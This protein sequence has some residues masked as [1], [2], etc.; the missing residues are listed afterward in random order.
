MSNAFS[1]KKIDKPHAK[2]TYSKA[3]FMQVEICVCKAALWSYFLWKELCILSILVKS[4]FLFIQRVNKVF[5]LKS[6][7][8]CKSRNLIYVVL[9]SRLQRKIYWRGLL[10]GRGENKYLSIA[11]TLNNSLAILH[12][13][14]SKN[15]SNF[16]VRSFLLIM[17]NDEGK[18]IP[19]MCSFTSWYFCAFAATSLWTYVIS[20]VDLPPLSWL[21]CW[22]VV[23]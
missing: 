8:N 18:S 2:R 22:K 5:I 10:F 14:S 17:S 9:L 16:C 4:L 12:L 19:M 20:P 6:K 3:T 23:L 13:S 21:R 15:V 1:G 11:M 7:F